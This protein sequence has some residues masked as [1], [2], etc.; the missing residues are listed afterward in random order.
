M[1]SSDLRC[2]VVPTHGEH[3]KLGIASTP[4]HLSAFSAPEGAFR[5]RSGLAD[6]RRLGCHT[7]VLG[8]VVVDVPPES[9]VHKQV[10]RKEADTRAIEL[11]PCT[12]LCFVEVEEPDMHKPSSDLE[13]LYKALHD[14]WQID[15][16]SCDV[17]L[18][19]DLQKTLRRGEWKVTAAVH[20]RVPG[21]GSR[22]AALWPGFHDRA[23]GL[24]IDEIGR[25]HV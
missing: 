12:R 9:Q 16:L 14:Q 13:R 10:V 22:L 8:D 11:D 18:V 23:F 20:S 7:R 6:D 15:N 1:C 25:A 2:Q 3:A 24:A 4:E 19:A 21:G 17:A 5:T